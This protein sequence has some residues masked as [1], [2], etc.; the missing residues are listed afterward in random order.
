MSVENDENDEKQET[1]TGPEVWYKNKDTV[2]LIPPKEDVLTSTIDITGWPAPWLKEWIPYH[3]PQQLK[4]DMQQWL[5]SDQTPNPSIIVIAY[6]IKNSLLYLGNGTLLLPNETEIDIK[7][8][9]SQWGNDYARILELISKRKHDYKGRYKYEIKEN[10]ELLGKRKGPD[11]DIME[12]DINGQP[13]AKK[14]RLNNNQPPMNEI[15][16][17]SDK[18][19]HELMQYSFGDLFM[20]YGPLY[21]PKEEKIN[22]EIVYKWVNSEGKS[23]SSKVRP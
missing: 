3:L 9:L 13:P 4:T 10:N 11:D 23:I 17:F 14:Q 22:D 18:T 1:Y 12:F 15:E 21:T 19:E 6:E 20:M 16:P 8:D 2:P 5:S 7:R